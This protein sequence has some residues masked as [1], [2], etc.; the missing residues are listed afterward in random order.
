[1]GMRARAGAAA[2]AAVAGAG[3]RAVTNGTAATLVRKSLLSMAALYF[4]GGLFVR[5]R[6]H[7]AGGL[8]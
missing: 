7:F 8:S 5:V 3:L 2:C 1:M 4:L 6:S